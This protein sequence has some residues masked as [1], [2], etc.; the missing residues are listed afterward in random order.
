MA[1]S[2]FNQF[3]L[4]LLRARLRPF[5]LHYFSTL[6]STNA[7]AAVMRKAKRLFAPAIVLTSNQTA[8]RGRGSNT[9]FSSAGSLTV[10]FVL[11]IDAHEP[12]QLPLI[13]GLAGRG[14]CAELSGYV[15]V[16]VKWPND[17]LA[18]GKKLGGLLCQRV[19][20]ADLVGIGINVNTPLK[21]APRTLRKQ[22]TSLEQ[23]AGRELDIND[24]LI[25]LASHLRRLVR[26]RNET[27]FAAFVEE[28]RR[29]DALAGKR[30]R[31]IG[32][33]GEPAIHGVCEGI[34]GSGRLLLRDRLITHRVIAGHV[35]V[36]K[37]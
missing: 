29:Y 27:S 26:Q 20:K 15:G 21:D 24:V 18:D 9:W 4:S 8:G 17:L 10:T 3:N 37:G 36:E 11:P 2:H 30:I 7:H 32:E 28:F 13:A 12:Q 1:I 35:V 23:L 6:R 31:I 22:I 33:N 5:R 19:D 25:A 34:D 16:M 14:A